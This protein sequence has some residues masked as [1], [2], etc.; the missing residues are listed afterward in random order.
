[1]TKTT[2]STKAPNHWEIF[3][4]L[5]YKERIT[6]NLKDYIKKYQHQFN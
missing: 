6:Y 2:K 1:M 4:N 5:K 3:E